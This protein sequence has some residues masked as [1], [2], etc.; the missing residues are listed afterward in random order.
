MNLELWFEQFFQT[1]MM[2][3]TSITVSEGIDAINIISEGD[4]PRDYLIHMH[5]WV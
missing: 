2:I 4:Y 3:G 1:L 5:G